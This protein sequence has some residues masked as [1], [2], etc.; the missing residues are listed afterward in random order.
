[1][2][3]TSATWDSP[4]LSALTRGTYSSSTVASGSL[5]WREAPPASKAR[6]GWRC[7]PQPALT[8]RKVQVAAELAEK[9]QWL[10]LLAEQHRQAASWTAVLT[11]QLGAAGLAHSPEQG[12]CGNGQN[13]E[14]QHGDCEGRGRRDGGNKTHL[15]KMHAAVAEE[16]RFGWVAFH[17]RNNSWRSKA[18]RDLEE[19]VSQQA[20]SYR[21]E[22]TSATDTGQWRFWAAEQ[23]AWLNQVPLLPT[24]WITAPAS[25][26]AFSFRAYICNQLR[27]LMVESGDKSSRD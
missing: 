26:E 14:T 10:Q 3:C 24:T 9:T 11:S 4:R 2:L 18:A 13:R 12:D 7:A 21:S 23:P 15:G 25:H 5:F 6:S 8:V 20:K 22:I 27:T 19:A 1:M 16:R 17:V